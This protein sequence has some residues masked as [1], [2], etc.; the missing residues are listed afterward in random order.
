MATATSTG[1]G[2]WSG[3]IWSGGSGSGGAPADG[4]AVVIAAGHS[5]LM[6]ADLSAWTGLQTVT[7]QGDDSTPGMLYFKAGT[8]GH[9]KIRTGYNLVGDSGANKGR[10]LANSDG[11][12]GN[13]GALAYANKAVID[14]QGTAKIDAQY[15]D[16]ALYGTEPTNKYVEVYGT[17]YTCTDQT[18]DVNASTDVITFTSAPPT[19]GTAVMVRSSGTLPGGLS[20]DA[21]YYTR[22]VS[23]NTCKLAL[24]NNDTTIVDITSTGSGTL[25]MY[26]GHTNTSTA[27]VNVIQD[28]TSDTPWV[29]TDG[30]DRVVLVDENAP[31]NYD[32][33]RVQLTTINAGSL[34]LSANVDSGQYPLARVYLVSR[35]VS[36]RSA[37]TTS[38]QPIVDY[39]NALTSSG[40]FQCE[41]INTGGTGT[42]FY[43]Y[44]VNSGSGHTI[45][46]TVSGCLYGVNSGSGHTISGTVSGCTYGVNSGSGHTISGTVSGCFYGVYSGSGHTISGTVSGCFYGVNSGSGHT[47]SGTVSGCSSGVYS[48]SGHTISGTVSGCLYG[49]N[50]GS[51]HT[52]SGTVSG[53]FYGV[54]H[55]G[56]DGYNMTFSGNTADVV[57]S[58]RE[59]GPL[60]RDRSFRHA[61]TANDTRA[62]SAGGSMTHE[63]SEKPSGKTYSH[64]FTYVDAAYWNVMEWEITRV[65]ALSLSI[66]VHAKHDGTG[67]AEAERI[68]WQ[69]VDPEDD[70]LLGGTA[71][72]EWIAA[73]SASWQSDT[74]SYERTDDRPLLLRVCAKRG[75]GNAYAYVEPIAAGVGGG[76]GGHILGRSLVR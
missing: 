66:T 53:C 21:V 3:A 31:D 10:L 64:K 43:G 36:I 74:V 5:V 71:L 73:D 63:T 1:S 8:S 48:G 7:I 68:H 57:Y 35:N 72:D 62:W 45:S 34:V 20:G 9:L 15:L 17:A 76:G 75:S 59:N 30:I 61:G 55:A 38:S 46:G 28:V 67:L 41:I 54:Y 44:G 65:E 27:T 26:S 39:V 22:T 19:A 51:G 40:V 52:I 50:S 29:T 4:D 2:S 60:L 69:I 49:V 32:L 18:T 6:D 33:Q 42:T 37:G 58:G 25:T 70:P 12:W 13:T 23:G 56:F 16:I 14:L 47:I 24:Q 11:V